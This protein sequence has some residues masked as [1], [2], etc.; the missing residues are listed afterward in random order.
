[1]KVGDL[2]IVKASPQLHWVGIIIEE[3]AGGE[4]D[5][6]IYDSKDGSTWFADNEDLTLLSEA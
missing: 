2:V 4:C 3:D 5:W 6:L 1:M